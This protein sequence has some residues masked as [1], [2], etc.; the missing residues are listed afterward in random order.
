MFG[1]RGVR[2]VLEGLGLFRGAPGKY[3]SRCYGDSQKGTPKPKLSFG[4]HICVVV[5]IMAPFWIPIILRH[6]IFMVPNKGPT[7]RL[8]VL[9]FKVLWDSGFG[10]PGCR[11]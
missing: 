1:V 11:V 2:A 10:L 5:K 4:T 6:L 3:E 8:R 9:G 7:T